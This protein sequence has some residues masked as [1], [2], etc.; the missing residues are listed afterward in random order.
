[1]PIGPPVTEPAL[2]YKVQDIIADALIEIGALAPS[3]VA[4]LDPDEAQWA[5]R[6]LNYLVDEWQ[7]QEIY[8]YSYN[9]SLY[10]LVPGLLPHTIGPQAGATFT[11][12]QAPRPVRL[13]SAAQLIN[14][15]AQTVDLGPIN[16]RDHDWWA[17]NQVKQIQ[18]NVVTDC[19]YAPD[20]PNGS[21][22][23]W[24]VPNASAQVRLQFWNTVQQF[25]N[26][27]DPIGGPGGPGTLPSAY[28]A[29]LMYTL[30]ERLLP[31][32]KREAHPALIQAAMKARAAIFGNNAKSPTMSTRDS[33]MPKA[34]RSG[35]RGDFNWFTGGAPGG[36]PE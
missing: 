32:E 29:A 1:M 20:S 19:Y 24:P 22:Y 9:F 33:G 2:S 4:N 3:E 26:I 30:A 11:T 17:A 35:V 25:D 10:T 7:A 5:F 12:N 8:V 21:L 14:T 16:I 23:F 36:R 6:K 28:R 18:T 15:G 13:E 27:L 34:G 31:G